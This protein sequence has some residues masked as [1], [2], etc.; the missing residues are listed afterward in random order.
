MNKLLLLLLLLLL[1]LLVFSNTFGQVQ[2][3]FFV[4]GVKNVEYVT[5][6][7]CVN[8]EAK[9]SEVTIVADKTTYENEYNI[10]QLRQYLLGVQYYPESKLK[11]NCYDS[12][13]EFINSSY[14]K[15]SLNKDE[16]NTCKKFRTGL[17]EYKHVLYKDTKIKRK[18][19][20][21][22]EIGKED[23]QIY[24]IKWL[25]G[26]IYVLTYK[27]MTEPRLKHLIGKEIHVEIIDI[28]DDGNYVYRSKANFQEKTDYGIIK[29][30][31]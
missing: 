10:E 8:D 23:K 15:K 3:T 31:K 4:E 22:R 24:Y 29:K 1:A 11:N 14:E 12:T 9:I 21:Q 26:C 25:S 5:V 19:K 17:Y 30:V 28:L 16:C 13:F 7:F 2:K 20:V 6:N 18:R 27:R